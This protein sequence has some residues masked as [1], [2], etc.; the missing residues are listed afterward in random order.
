M[1]ACAYHRLS[2]SLPGGRPEHVVARGQQLTAAISEAP[3]QLPELNTQ[4]LSNTAQAL[5]SSSHGG[6]LLMTAA[7]EASL[8]KLASF[9]REETEMLLWSLAPWC[10]ETSL[11]VLRDM[12]RTSRLRALGQPG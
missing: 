11:K 2:Q 7:M 9:R 5:A 1:I 4:D 8:I 10:W 12:D 6:S 3:V